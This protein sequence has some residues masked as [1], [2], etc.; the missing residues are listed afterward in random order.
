MGGDIRIE[1]QAG[2]GTLIKFHIQVQ[3]SSAAELSPGIQANTEPPDASE[4]PTGFPGLTSDML[5]AVMPIDWVYR[6]HQAAIRGFDQL[7]F[8]LIQ[9]IPATQGAIAKTLARWSRNFQFDKILA[10]T[11]PIVEDGLSHVTR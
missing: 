1:S 4:E 5:R 11:Q 9:E 10:L 8:Q 7:I 6:L 2:K 3:P